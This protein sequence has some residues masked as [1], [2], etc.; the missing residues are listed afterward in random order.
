M[1]RDAVDPGIVFEI[2]Y[3]QKRRRIKQLAWDYIQQSRAKVR[4]VISVDIEYGERNSSREA[5]IS[6]WRPGMHFEPGKVVFRPVKTVVNQ[7]SH[8]TKYICH[9]VHNH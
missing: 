6:M 8:S 1:H 5:T 2:T 9:Q 3:L 7:V 4:L